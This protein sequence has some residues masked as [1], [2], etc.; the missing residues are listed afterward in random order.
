MVCWNPDDDSGLLDITTYIGGLVTFG[1]LW[2]L[3]SWCRYRSIFWACHKWNTPSFG[4]IVSP[5]IKIRLD[6]M[7]SGDCPLRLTRQG[8]SLPTSTR[9]CSS[10][11][12]YLHQSPQIQSFIKGGLDWMAWPLSRAQGQLQNGCWEAKELI[13]SLCRQEVPCKTRRR[14]NRKSKKS[15]ALRDSRR[16]KAFKMPE[17]YKNSSYWTNLNCDVNKN[18]NKKCYGWCYTLMLLSGGTLNNNKYCC[19][20]QELITPPPL[21]LFCLYKLANNSFW[22]SVSVLPQKESNSSSQSYSINYLDVLLH[23][24]ELEILMKSWWWLTCHSSVTPPQHQVSVGWTSGRPKA[25][26]DLTLWNKHVTWS[27]KNS[28]IRCF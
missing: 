2:L 9:V 6:P 3:L 5:K 15:F 19:G 26:N 14:H 21:P 16:R 10:M 27:P 13:N 25:L 20:L 17:D 24:P 11:L 8:H 22:A 18:K 4:H 23:F 12:C 7:S 1:H 28:I